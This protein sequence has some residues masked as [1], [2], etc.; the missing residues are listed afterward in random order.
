MADLKD[1]V[2]G[3]FRI[4]NEIKGA[5]GSQGQ[6]FKAVCENPPFD[7]IETGTVVAL[8]VMAV[9]DEDGQAWAKLERRTGELV[10]LSHQNVV[11]Y[12]GCFSEQGT[13]N[14]THAIVQE[15]LDGETLKQRL[16]RCPSGLDADEAL[17]VTESALAGLEYT[18]KRGIVHRDIKPANIFLCL[19]NA[20]AIVGV[21][22][23]DFEIARQEGG[24]TTS[25]SGNMVGSFDYMAPDFTTPSF[26]GDEVSD[27]FSMGVVMHETITGRTPYQHAD[28][29]SGRADIAFLSRWTQLHVDGTNPIRIS[30]RANRLLAYSGKVLERALAPDPHK[31]YGSFSEFREGLKEIR[32][33]HIKN[34]DKVYRILQLIGKGGFGEVFKARQRGD[35]RLV[36]IKH[37]LKEAY[38]ERFYREAAIM[39]RIDDPC[40]VRFM[41]FFKVERPGNR[42]AFLVM[43]YLPGMPGN[44]LRDA[45]KRADGAALPTSDTLRAF[46]RFAHGLSIIH[47]RGIIHRDIKPSNLYYPEG[48][49]EN[50]AIMDLG[51]ARDAH[52]SITTGQVPGTLDYM[53]PEVVLTDNRGESGMDIY[54]LGLCL[55]EALSG[56]TA[57]PRL[58][59]GQAGVVALIA[60]SKLHVPPD[61][62]EPSILE[63]KPLYELLVE[64]TSPDISKR[65]VDSRELERRLAELAMASGAGI[66]LPIPDDLG[67]ENPEQATVTFTIAHDME[68]DPHLGQNEDRKTEDRKTAETIRIQ[69]HESPKR[70]VITIPANTDS[71]PETARSNRTL[72][73]L[74]LS[75]LAMA[76]FGL[77]WWALRDRVV[78]WLQDRAASAARPEAERVVA[79]YAYRG[80]EAGRRAES[81][82]LAR[83]APERRHWVDL[84]ADFFAACTNRFR[85]AEM[86]LSDKEAESALADVLAA[87]ANIR[88]ADA[89]CE[90]RAAEWRTKWVPCCSSA[91]IAECEKKIGV[92]QKRRA[93][94]DSRVKFDKFRN[95]GLQVAMLYQMEDKPLN[96]CD[97]RADQWRKLRPD[98]FPDVDMEKLETKIKKAKHDR[99]RADDKRLA[100]QELVEVVKAYD[101]GVSIGNGRADAWRVKWEKRIDSAD[102]EQMNTKIVTA[103]SKRMETEHKLREASKKKACESESLPILAGYRDDSSEK[104]ENDAK[105]AEWIGRWKSDHDLPAGWFNS[106]AEQIG[107]EKKAREA[108]INDAG[109]GVRTSAR[110]ALKGVIDVYDDRT[111]KIEEGEKQAALTNAVESM[112]GVLVKQYN[113]DQGQNK[114]A[115]DGRFDEWTK[116][117]ESD[118]VLRKSLPGWFAGR[119]KTVE[120]AK[121]ACEARIAEAKRNQLVAAKTNDV[122]KVQA[123]LV[124]GYGNDASDK[125]KLDRAFTDWM[126]KWSA[127]TELPPGYFS[128][129]REIVEKEKAAREQ[130]DAN[131]ARAR[132]QANFVCKSYRTSGVDAGN[133]GRTMWRSNWTNVLDAATF[134]ELSKDIDAVRDE[135]VKILVHDAFDKKTNEVVSA[136]VVLVKGYEAMDVY[137]NDVG[138]KKSEIDSQVERWTNR[139]EA[140]ADLRKLQPDWF[141]AQ[142]RVVE[143]ARQACEARIATA[144]QERIKQRMGRIEA[145]RRGLEEGYKNDSSDKVKLDEEFKERVKNWR[146]EGDLKPGWIDMQMRAVEKEKTAREE[147]MQA[148]EQAKLVCDMYRRES[149]AKGDGSRTFWMSNWTGKLDAAVVKE[150]SGEIDKAREE[151]VQKDKK[152]D[153]IRIEKE[154]R[155]RIEKKQKQVEREVGSLVSEYGN[156]AIARTETD[157]AF[158]RWRATWEADADLN[159]DWVA[160]QR[161]NIEKARTARIQRDVADQNRKDA[162]DAADRVCKGYA[163]GV[164]VGDTERQLWDGKWKP[165]LAESDYKKITDIIYKSRE[166]AQAKAEAERRKAECERLERECRALLEV[167]RNHVERW[168]KQLEEVERKVAD[169]SSRGVLDAQEAA[170][171]RGEVDQRK[172]WIVGVV[173]NRSQYEIEVAKRRTGPGQREFFEYRGTM[174]VGGLQVICP[175][176]KA[177]VIDGSALD[178]SEVSIGDG[179]WKLEPIP[180]ARVRIPQLENGVTCRLGGVVRGSGEQVEVDSGKEYE[181]VYSRK[182]H[183]NQK[184]SFSARGGE[185]QELP[186]PK[187]WDVSPKFKKWCQTRLVDAKV[188]LTSGF[189]LACL[190]VY[191][192]M[193]VEGYRLNHNDLETVE[194]AW[195]RC[196]EDFKKAKEVAVVRGR[197]NLQDAEKVWKKARKFYNELTGKDE[198]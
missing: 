115:I 89:A 67:A 72:R 189:G 191:H 21:K 80:K 145:D 165:V 124:S 86:E 3:G 111:K 172:T 83:W 77:V 76:A 197:Y 24:T 61:F 161:G 135:V 33:R 173:A 73:V 128:T 143:S 198:S 183:E 13:F 4:L 103:R 16:A 82:W 121:A 49:P 27:I 90:K 152:D 18:A 126:L 41:D 66:D 138:V 193:H 26:K 43:N 106:L 108:R 185:L 51:I 19:D 25:A 71:I 58:P 74:A 79:A 146:A 129:Q 64:M 150:L 42:E 40:F 105:Y 50:A 2:I 55:Y 22:L 155:T 107:K 166:A 104:K 169:G 148:R 151:R 194:E 163:S 175:G 181:Y 63:N 116:K 56:K 47:S 130:R 75:A 180:K 44:S 91:M 52:G 168:R 78:G 68:A 158:S 34:G 29:L 12:Y 171:L 167:D 32:Y 179:K 36:A 97:A 127:D 160:T 99:M 11:K 39:H 190:E 9:H 156:M 85:A 100:E 123:Q 178:G 117:W 159:A 48:Q 87:F 125:F 170:A 102:F 113:G 186:H 96:D 142:R 93:E 154:R 118:E 84:E 28:E 187:E 101:D 7:G 153:A 53:P 57:Y 5:S 65:L 141:A 17:H 195:E 95:A 23:I 37:L 92:A 88:E 109:E 184:G 131:K 15:F 14:D 69:E 60:R 70:P 140:D 196:D 81:D 8:K 122:A 94:R 46:A 139:W 133:A 98:G 6:V 30:S 132:E 147:R 38:A 45:I 164:E 182:N 188:S 31:R 177:L 114:A 174:P 157:G 176:H 134:N 120:D 35:G 54:A 162:Y 144:V 1:K 112:R 136:C 62:S 137:A 59:Q 10:R 149:V 20:G 119:K 110:E 192:E